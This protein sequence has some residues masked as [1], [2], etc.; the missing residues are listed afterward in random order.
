MKIEVSKLKKGDQYFNQKEGW[1]E[2]DHVEYDNGL[3]KIWSSDGEFLR[4]G[5]DGTDID[6][7]D[8]WNI[9]QVRIAGVYRPT[10]IQEQDMV[11]SPSHYQLVNGLEV[12]DIR[13][14]IFDKIPMGKLSYHQAD[15]YSRAW[16]YLTRACFKHESPLEDL[17]KAQTYLTWL[18]ED[19]SDKPLSN[20]KTIDKSDIHGS[21]AATTENGE[22]Q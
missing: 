9:T 1:V 17:Q 11:N 6:G 2:V 7:D 19:M 5:G 21:L 15:C 16:E 12:K 14:A 8:K 10:N 4:V 20:T 3:F 13:K 22:A 18:I